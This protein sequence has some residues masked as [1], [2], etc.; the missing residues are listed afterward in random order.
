[1]KKILNKDAIKY[2]LKSFLK[3]NKKSLSFF[4]LFIFVKT[5][6]IAFINSYDN[7][8]YKNENFY[9]LEE[10][11]KSF[12]ESKDNFFVS[13]EKEKE[14]FKKLSIADKF[15]SLFFSNFFNV[16]LD[17]N[18]SNIIE[19]SIIKSFTII[20]DKLNINI[21]FSKRESSS[22][23]FFFK[24]FFIIYSL[25]IFTALFFPF[26]T[27]LTSFRE[28]FYESI[29]I[30]MYGSLLE[31]SSKSDDDKFVIINT[32]WTRSEIFFSKFFVIL[33]VS[34]L[35]SI[36]GSLFTS[37]YCGILGISFFQ[38]FLFLFL[39]TF[40]FSFIFSIHRKVLNYLLDSNKSLLAISKL[41][42]MLLPVPFVYFKSSITKYMS[43]WNLFS[44]TSLLI[45]LIESFIIWRRIKDYNKFDFKS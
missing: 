41:F 43:I 18:I 20:S 17:S 39:N 31:Y 36:P 1:M 42:F 34:F 7:Y 14:S 4:F 16:N 23:S 37:L 22:S 6:F 35:L 9:N 30:K 25:F 32:S 45:F 11:G 26:Y 28:I 27:A 13:E 21:D 12:V 24:F 40:I 2:Y 3:F 38:S 19:N 44:I 5:S 15:S 8:A 29:F 10:L 33:L